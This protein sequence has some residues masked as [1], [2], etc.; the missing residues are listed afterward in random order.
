MNKR[1]NLAVVAAAL[2]TVAPIAT[3]ATTS[4]TTFA[5]TNSVRRTLTSNAFIYSKSAK[6]L[7]S[8]FYKKGAKVKTYG[9]AVKI[10]GKY[11]YYIGKNQYIKR[12][13]FEAAVNANT[14][15]LPTDYASALDKYNNLQ[16]DGSE[17]KMIK[18]SKEAVK[19][20]NFHSESKTDDHTKATA[21]QLTTSQMKELN[22]YALQ[23]LNSARKQAD[24][25]TIK[26]D[27]NIQ[28]KF[29]DE[30]D[31]DQVK[32]TFQVKN[33]PKTMTGMK[34]VVYN[35]LKKML[36]NGAYSDYHS[37]DRANTLLKD[38]NTRAGIWLSGN[39]K[40]AVLNWGVANLASE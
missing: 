37:F 39:S 40:N 7:G 32:Y 35:S 13:N 11:Y 1:F 10:K 17:N 3:N 8:M 4:S 22:N 30:N 23:L 5:A 15:K 2:M 14:I 21:P 36:F 12:A 29:T 28:S 16:T 27:Y 34:H 19:N 9:A 31:W 18:L 38:S 24:V 25:S 6:R 26:T 20:N 33:Y